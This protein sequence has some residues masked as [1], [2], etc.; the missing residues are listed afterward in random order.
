MAGGYRALLRDRRF[1]LLLLSAATGE[2]GY[3]LYSLSIV[4]LAYREFG[5]LSVVGLVLGVEFGVYALVFLA[6]PI[7]D[8]ARDL[9][10]VWLVGYPLQAAGAF[11]IAFLATSRSLSLLTLLPLVAGLSFV[12][13]FTWTAT[14]AAP[15]RLVPP[16]QL[17][18]A[19]GLLAAATGGNQVAGYTAGALLL[20]FVGPAGGLLAY[21]V[22]NLAAA[23]VAAGVALPAGPRLQPPFLA[24]LADGFRY[25]FGRSSGALR[26]FALWGALQGFISP[27]PLLLLPLLTSAR[28]ANP[29]LAYGLLFA[30]FGVGGILGALA[31]GAANLRS[32]VGQLLVGALLAEGALFALLLLLP[33]AL[34]SAVPLWAAIG[35]VDGTYWLVFLAYL[36]AASP[37]ELLARTMADGYLVR[38][39]ARTAGALVLGVVGAAAGVAGLGDLIAAYFLLLAGG[40][41]AVPVLRRLRY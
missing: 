37:P 10:S 30:S 17:F 23:V 21:G 14:N 11:A 28:F 33:S 19:N 26:P 18:Q 8:R 12:W 36:Q 3:A 15:P 6:G 16:G 22:L 27:A 5:S 7:V 2:A 41:L 24:G 34:P 31:V 25:L 20:V 4:W 39:S 38:G 29:S 35:I 9:R 1:A 40:T 32:R 13:D